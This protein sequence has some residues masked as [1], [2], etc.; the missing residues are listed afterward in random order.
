MLL[1]KSPKKLGLQLV[2]KTFNPCKTYQMRSLKASL[3]G[4]HA[5]GLKPFSLGLPLVEAFMGHA[6]DA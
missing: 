1:L 3:V 4:R 5:L 6:A 2:Q